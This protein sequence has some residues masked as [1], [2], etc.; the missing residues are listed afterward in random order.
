MWGGDYTMKKCLGGTMELGKRMLRCWLKYDY[1]E[2]CS[3]VPVGAFDLSL[4]QCQRGALKD[5]ADVSGFGGS[6]FHPRSTWGSVV[7]VP[8]WGFV[9]LV[10]VLICGEKEEDEIAQKDLGIL[11]ERNWVL[12]TQ[13]WGFKDS[14]HLCQC[15]TRLLIFKPANP[16]GKR[17][18]T[19]EN[20]AAVGQEWGCTSKSCSLRF[21]LTACALC[22]K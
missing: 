9:F 22:Q 18:L 3:C 17:P 19:W 11:A 16:T 12:Q 2:F 20:L 5:K 4:S 13:Q 8:G 7:C 6:L 21:K 14:S 15:N 10:N 1:R